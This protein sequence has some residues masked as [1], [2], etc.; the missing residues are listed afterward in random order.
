M[1]KTHKINVRISEKLKNA[2][3]K[4]L[5]ENDENKSEVIRRFIKKY[6]RKSTQKNMGKLTQKN[7]EN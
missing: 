6:I 7:M 3:T 1:N 2:F 4:A 5:E